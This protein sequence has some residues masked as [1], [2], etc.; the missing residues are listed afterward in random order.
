[1]KHQI[2]K[3]AWISKTIRYQAIN[4]SHLHHF[5]SQGQNNQNQNQYTI[6][7][8]DNDGNKELQSADSPRL[9]GGQNP[10]PVS[11]KPINKTKVEIQ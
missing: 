1:M 2:R 8:S 5:F 6:P 10:T 11:K 4:F 3:A 7:K 9:E